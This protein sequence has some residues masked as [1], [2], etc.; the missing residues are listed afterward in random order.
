MSPVTRPVSVDEL[1]RAHRSLMAGD[2]RRHRTHVGGRDGWNP[3]EPVLPVVGAAGGTG[4][5]TLALA[6]ATAAGGRV[7]ECA[8]VTASGLAGAPTAELGRHDSGWLQGTRETVLIERPAQVLT[9]AANVPV[10]TY[11]PTLPPLTVVDVAWELGQVLATPS[12]LADLLRDGPTVVVA[13][14][15]TIPG[16]RRLEAALTMLGRSR[17]DNGVVAAVLQPRRSGRARAAFRSAGPHTAALIRAERLVAVPTVSAL[18]TRGLDSAPL[19]APLLD[20][21]TRLLELTDTMPAR[22]DHSS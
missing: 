22:K 6:L 12:W 7:V 17:F 21:A 4:A 16:L 2:F 20:A 18:S 14:T 10:P 1:L 13:A 9:T 19:P 8:S 3:A 15:A 5:S 11:P